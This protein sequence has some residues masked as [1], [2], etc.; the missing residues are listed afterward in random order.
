MENKIRSLVVYCVLKYKIDQTELVFYIFHDH[1]SIC[2]SVSSCILR[3]NYHWLRCVLV[4][5]VPQSVSISA[6][7]EV[8][9][10]FSISSSLS[11]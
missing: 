5:A 3:M 2:A 8:F 4:F 7:S 1:R 11:S 9:L 6:E 10:L